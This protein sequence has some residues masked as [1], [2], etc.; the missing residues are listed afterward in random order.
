MPCDR[1]CTEHRPVRLTATLENEGTAA[2]PLALRTWDEKEME[3]IVGGPRDELSLEFQ[4]FLEA[5]GSRPSTES[6]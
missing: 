3:A 6:L 2:H 4:A 5:F 1:P